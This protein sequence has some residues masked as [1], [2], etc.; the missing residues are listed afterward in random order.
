MGLHLCWIGVESH[1]RTC[2]LEWFDLEP[3]GEVDDE[4]GAEFTLAETAD[5]WVV[6][7]ARGGGFDLDAA[8][9][10]VSSSCGFAVGC[11]IV[12]G[13]T[14]SRASAS[15]D[16]QRLWWVTYNDGD[17]GSLSAAGEPPG[18]F[19]NIRDELAAKQVSAREGVTYLFDAPAQLAASVTGYRPGEDLAL[20]WTALRKRQVKAAR[21]GAAPRSLRGAMLSQLVPL[22]RTLG[23]ESPDRPALA[24]MWQICRTNDGV[25]QTIW[26]EYGSGQ[27]TYVIVH[28]FARAGSGPADFA[29]GGRVT[30]P[31]QRLPLWKRFTWTRL[32][33]LTRYEPP[34]ADLVG[35][36]IE[37]A[38]AEVRI[39]DQYLRTWS[40]SP[41][42]LVEFAQPPAEWPS[43]VRNGA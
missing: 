21:R 7:A 5:G 39:A 4:L 29:V 41:C 8:L 17:S 31:R 33:E 24:D 20:E 3:A 38:G 12:E 28:F 26:F 43:P 13:A 2:L 25:E 19:G 18:E 1:R 16:G 34:P 37:R 15:R 32:S 14:F 9:A 35:A 36:V 42:I 40:P 23:W 10:G 30:A 11:E 22:L 6:L 27:E